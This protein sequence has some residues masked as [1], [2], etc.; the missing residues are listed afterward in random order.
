MSNE[1]FC[2]D[3]DY[4]IVTQGTHFCKRKFVTKL[5][6]VTGETSTTA[7]LLCSVE[8]EPITAHGSKRCGEEAKYYKKTKGK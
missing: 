4:H 1:K 3:C 8:R 2:I 7:D 5:D 6:L